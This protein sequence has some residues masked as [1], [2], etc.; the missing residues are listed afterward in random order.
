M[1]SDI[2]ENYSILPKGVDIYEITGPFFFG[3]AQSY[4]ETLK[5][6]AGDS[7]VLI[8][9]MRYVPFIDS[10][11]ISNFQEV[12]RDFKSRKV[13]VIIS[14]ARPGVRETLE[15]CG[16]SAIIGNDLICD[17]FGEAVR[18]ASEE[19]DKRKLFRLGKTDD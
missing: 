4:K 12:I 3:A 1:D 9:R 10:T 16:L 14:G 6:I 2:L 17:N 11:G 8:L 18:K 13:T 7:K 15:S 5:Q 19:L